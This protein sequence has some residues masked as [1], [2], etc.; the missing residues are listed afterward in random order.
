METRTLVSLLDRPDDAP[1]VLKPWRVADAA[2]ARHVLLDLAD[3]GVTLDLL[4]TLCTQL[5]A[6]LPEVGDA[7]SVLEG[8][9]QIV[10]ASRSP[11]SFA[12]LAERDTTT[13]PMLV[14][15]LD[16][17]GVWRE[18][19]LRDPEA[20]DLLRLTEGQPVDRAT[21]VADITAE[22]TNLHDERSLLADL[23]RIKR[24]EQLRI[25]YG[26][27]VARHKPELVWQQLTYLA[28]AL[29]TAA[30]AAALQK[31]QAT[32]PVAGSV[33]RQSALGAV[34]LLAFGRC[35]AGEQDYS[36]RLQ[37]LLLHD[38]LPADDAKRRAAADQYERLARLFFRLIQE[39][40]DL[41]SL[42]QVEL[43]A[44]PSRETPPSAIAA[45]EAAA[46]LDE[47]GR[48]WHR[49]SFTQARCVAGDQQLAKRFLQQVEPWIY[50]RLLS[51]A[52][53]A[54]LRA[55]KRRIIRRAELALQSAAE[56]RDEQPEMEFGPGGLFDFEQT[57]QFL[58]LLSGGDQP[59]VRMPGTLD[60]IAGLEQAGAINVKERTALEE[61][62]VAL[63]RELH[64]AQTSAHGSAA[65]TATAAKQSL[66]SA[67][68]L[69]KSLLQ[70]A[71]PDEPDPPAEVDLLLAPHPTAAEAAQILGPYRFED[72]SLALRHL[73]DLANERTPYLSTRRC[74]YFLSAIIGRLLKAI[75]N[76]PEPD[77]TLAN[78]SRVSDSLG[79]KGV[80]WELFHAHQPS[81]ELYVRV[82]GCSPY[83]A[84]L[85]TTNPGMLDELLDSLQLA[86]HP[87]L[88]TLQRTWQELQRS[89]GPP[90]PKLAALKASRHLQIG[91]R[92]LLQQE[93]IEITHRALSDVAEVSIAAVAEHEYERLVEKHGRPMIQEGPFA[94]E[95]C[96]GV[97]LG[98]GKLGG[99]EPN[100]HS[101]LQIAVVYE[102]EG[103]TQPAERSKRVQATTNG[104]FFTQLAQRVLKEVSQSTPQGR[105]YPL[106]AGLRPLG[107][108]GP[109]ANS[110]TDLA[111]HFQSGSAPLA[112]WQTLLK[113]RPIFGPP[114]LRATT[115]NAIRQWLTVRPWQLADAVQLLQDRLQLDQGAAALNIKRGVGG[116]LDIEYAVQRWQLEHA[117]R[118]PRILEP[119]T[120]TAIQALGTAG[121][122]SPAEAEQWSQSYRL[123]RRIEC[124]I[125]LL[126]S[127]DRHVL[128][129]EK[130]ALHRLALLLGYQSPADLHDACM[131]AMSSN[132]TR[133][134][135]AFANAKAVLDEDLV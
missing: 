98:L 76:T 26:E 18:T 2:A 91:V 41:G 109:L 81:L 61:V 58:R 93:P 75:A 80:L 69:L 96:G 99:Q 68:A 111:A 59:R 122:L 16:W 11:L 3:A 49:Q 112:H 132:R 103:S 28:E 127:R 4:A 102:I 101:D 54:G 65:E 82:C 87:D 37:L 24:R 113:A 126:N 50:R 83:L 42:Y 70:A 121:I 92:D 7:N 97:I 43:Q 19:I 66:I 55:L 57:L 90:L 134:L 106:E 29:L 25:V 116:T 77:V 74:R 100:Y 5:D 119:G 27:R 107:A 89:G 39:T 117:H 72:C 95:P 14:R 38:P 53:E 125:R 62:Y 46:L 23:R 21:L 128:P 52:D 47:F 60:A 20:F 133:F 36:D 64:A 114:A 79:G 30:L 6:L 32:K 131:D 108:S 13:L 94:G 22:V 73:N 1:A 17:G 104:H 9:R 8:L 84:D 129:G 15:V 35:G 51:P 45:N 78:L 123:L 105:L 40:T 48:T 118:E 88:A 34:A 71:F 86:R 63:R 10:L 44:L 31:Q 135:K 120:L 110:L 12:A 67:L 33:H 85:M 115:M 56:C 130:F 124:G